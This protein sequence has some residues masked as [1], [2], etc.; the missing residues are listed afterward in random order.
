MVVRA[1]RCEEGALLRPNEG[2]QTLLVG[3]VKIVPRPPDEVCG[4]ETAQLIFQPATRP[5][6]AVSLAFL[7]WGPFFLAP[8]LLARPFCGGTAGRAGTC[9]APSEG[10][11]VD[12]VLRQ[13][14]A[15]Q[16]PRVLACQSSSVSQS[17][18][19]GTVHAMSAVAGLV[20]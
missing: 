7:C 9:A 5:E 19:L 8:T 2:A 16:L 13:S 1:I 20:I 10:T 18:S 14:A 3:T 15:Q 17:L 12:D 4:L 11:A 6:L